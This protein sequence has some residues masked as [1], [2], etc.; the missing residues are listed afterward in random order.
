VD[1]LQNAPEEIPV[2]HAYCAIVTLERMREQASDI[3]KAAALPKFITKKMTPSHGVN[4]NMTLLVGIVGI[5][6]SQ[7]QDKEV[8]HPPVSHLSLK[9]TR[10][11]M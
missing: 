9:D 8:N 10:T 7:L 2:S 3:V 6:I 1:L 5:I 11:R 4:C